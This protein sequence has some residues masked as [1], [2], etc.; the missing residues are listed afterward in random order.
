[1]KIFD[2]GICLVGISFC[3]NAFALTKST[4]CGFA[5][6]LPAGINI[7][8]DEETQSPICQYL[9]VQDKSFPFVN[10][11]TLI[12][13]KTMNSSNLKDSIRSSG[14]FRFLPSQII[15]YEGRNSYNDNRNGYQQL[16]LH[17]TIKPT[18]SIQNRRI[19]IVFSNL[20]VTWQKPTENSLPEETTDVF[21]CIDAIVLDK[22]SIVLVNWC[23]KTGSPK[24]LALSRAIP[25]ISL[26]NSP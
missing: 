6:D 14:F 10:R 5:V 4:E 1:M 3:T 15:K 25:G 23:A 20:R 21:E 26:P 13:R 2:L 11:F 24:I 18:R 17:K 12:P 9:E 16:L 7:I 22:L 19:M 8:R